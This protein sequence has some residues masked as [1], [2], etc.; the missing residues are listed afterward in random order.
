MK[1]EHTHAINTNISGCSENS[2]RNV[3]RRCGG[4]NYTY[5]NRKPST[6]AEEIMVIIRNIQDLGQLRKDSK[7]RLLARYLEKEITL[8]YRDYKCENLDSIGVFVY[9][10][11]QADFADYKKIGLHEPLDKALFELSETLIFTD[12]ITE[13]R[14]L[15]VVYVPSDSFAASVFM[16]H[17]LIYDS[18]KNHAFGRDYQGERFVELEGN[19]DTII[20]L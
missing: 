14:T 15:N 10:E 8:L 1:G 7:T 19:N 17:E 20:F 6:K 11:S 2:D 9:L 13:F 16:R 5:D 4:W 18:L 12:G 3:R